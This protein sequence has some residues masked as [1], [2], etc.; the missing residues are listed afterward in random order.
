MEELRETGPTDA[1]T[2][3][4][5][6]FADGVM[7][8]AITLLILEI[9]V[10]EIHGEH[11]LA[12]ALLD[13]WPSYAAY[14]V[15]FITIGIMW[16]NHHHM[17]KLIRR[18]DHTFLVLNVLFLMT[19]AFLPWPTALLAEYARDPGGRTAGAMIYGVTMLLIAVMFNLVWRYAG[20]KHRLLFAGVSDRMVR[21]TNNS[22]L[23][24]PIIYGSAALIALVNPLIS[25]AIYA[26]LA[27]YWLLPGTGPRPE[28]S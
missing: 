7:A 23:L 13:Q 27:I 11:S 25:L 17:F 18:A 20:G 5:E 10:P 22:Y 4:L 21:R 19:I 26:A 2:S 14:F 12:R 24:G 15:S 8:I 16:I 1:D 9:K 6:T 28:K 3:R